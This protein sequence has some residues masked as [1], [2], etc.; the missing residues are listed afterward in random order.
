[1][2]ILHSLCTHSSREMQSFE[3][4]RSSV[5]HFKYCFEKF[6][7][8]WFWGFFIFIF[9]W[10]LDTSPLTLLI[11][12]RQ[13]KESLY[14]WSS[15]AW[16]FWEKSAFL[17]YL[18]HW[19]LKIGLKVI[20]IFNRRV[21]LVLPN[22]FIL[23]GLHYLFQN[24]LLERNIYVTGNLKIIFMTILTL[25][26][27]LRLRV[28]GIFLSSVKKTIFWGEKKSCEIHGYFC[29]QVQKKHQWECQCLKSF[30]PFQR[31]YTEF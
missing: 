11:R 17:F 15:Q 1:M 28:N 10:M 13:K 22:F 7:H 12:T 26:L 6:K 5:L 18:S 3:W 24:V 31:I 21:L 2:E 8:M 9:F 20:V 30:S 14:L 27:T 23:L 19:W 29:Y 16:I 25:T 4:D